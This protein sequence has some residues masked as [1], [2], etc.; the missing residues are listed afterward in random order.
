VVPGVGRKAL[1]DLDARN[2]GTGLT[3]AGFCFSRLSEEMADTIVNDSAV[4]ERARKRVPEL[5]LSTLGPVSRSPDGV[6]SNIRPFILLMP[7]LLS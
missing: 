1:A 2:R 7:A 5:I 3:S 4:R 6:F